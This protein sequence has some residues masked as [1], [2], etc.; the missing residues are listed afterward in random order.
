MEGG[1]QASSTCS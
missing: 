1:C